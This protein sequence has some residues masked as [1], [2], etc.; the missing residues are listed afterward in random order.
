MY[1]CCVRCNIM[2]ILFLGKTTGESRIH[3]FEVSF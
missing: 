3:V 2:F 1:D